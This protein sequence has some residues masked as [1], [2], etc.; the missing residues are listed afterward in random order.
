MHKF[1]NTLDTMPINWYLQV[2]L[3]LTTSD[4]Y[5]MTQNFLAT[6]LFESQY[7]LVD[8]SLQVVRQ[9]L[10]EAPNLP[11]EKE[12]DEWTASLQKLKGCYNSNVHEDDDPRNVKITKTEGQRDVE[13]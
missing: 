8:K 13:G 12:E 5:G 2:E 4:W 10:F 9:K 11:L 6:F 3:C 7:P 1:I